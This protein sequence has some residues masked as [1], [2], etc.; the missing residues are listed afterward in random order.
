[1]LDYG[2]GWL[3]VGRDG[4]LYRV[5]F[6]PGGGWY[7]PEDHVYVNDWTVEEVRTEFWHRT[8]PEWKGE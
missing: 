1:M 3:F 8:F 6:D 5:D 7:C 4:L 2:D